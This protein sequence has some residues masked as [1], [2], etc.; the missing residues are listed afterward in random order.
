MLSRMDSL[1]I[2]L[3]YSGECYIAAVATPVLVTMTMHLWKNYSYFPLVMD[4][5]NET[6]HTINHEIFHEIN[7]RVK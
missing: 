2:L 3:L 6:H 4:S 1:Q 5:C 7:F